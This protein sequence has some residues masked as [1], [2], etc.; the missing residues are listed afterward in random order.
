MATH[1]LSQ[2]DANLL[3]VLDAL[4]REVSVTRAARRVGLSQSAMSH[5][6]ARLR[7][8]LGDPLLV[9]AGRVMVLT[10]RAEALAPR[11]HRVV[12]EME[13]IFAADAPFSPAELD[14]AFRVNTTDHVQF[15]LVPALDTRLGREA[16]GVDLYIGSI[17]RGTFD[18][19]RA[20][21]IDAAIGVFADVP[22]D[23]AQE[24]L[25]EDRF[26]CVVRADHP[27]VKR[28]LTLEQYASL[29]HL[30][31]APRGEPR[32]LIDDLLA[33]HGLGRRVARAVPHFLV[34][35]FLAASSD[36][37]LTLSER[38]ATQMAETLPLRLLEPPLDIAPYTLTLVWHQ[39]NDG[40]AA[41]AWLRRC[42]AEVAAALPPAGSGRRARR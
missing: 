33:T 29:P 4:L 32:G 5:A 2:L 38:L 28:K 16:P 20:G 30:L 8:H 9:R 40:D 12:G 18:E 31:V 27:V 13:T 39:R 6:L 7:D 37:V 19:L 26:V 41:H 3:V 10:P 24:A 17:T 42:I 1:R 36:Y 25:F 23:V 21:S 11:V 22:P 14:R 34:A 35:P 15:L